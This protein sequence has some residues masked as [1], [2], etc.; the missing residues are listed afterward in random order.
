[1][2]L[3]VFNAQLLFYLKNLDNCFSSFFILNILNCKMSLLFIVANRDMD[4]NKEFAI[5]YQVVCHHN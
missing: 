1:M 3:V 4:Y 2:Y 5:E